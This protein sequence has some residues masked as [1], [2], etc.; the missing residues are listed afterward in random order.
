MRLLI[1]TLAASSLA[2]AVAL[3]MSAPTPQQADA[4]DRKLNT[5]IERGVHE[6]SGHTTPFAAD[7]LNAYLQ[8][9]MADRFP[10]GVTEPSVTFLGQGRLSGSAIVDLDGIR[11]KSSGGWLDPT[12]YLSGRLPVTAIGTLQT[13]DGSGR[14]VIESAD[15]SGITIPKALLQEVVTYY[16]RSPELPRGVNLDDPFDLPLGIQRIDVNP[17][18]AIVVQ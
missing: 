14:F 10:S 2:T 18:V 13:E 9:R 5:V 4:F 12:A 16:T 8:L 3:A 1:A 6:P 11:K 15:V 17:G 7:E